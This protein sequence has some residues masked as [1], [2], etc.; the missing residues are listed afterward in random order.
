MQVFWDDGSFS[1]DFSL[2]GSESWSLML[3]VACK[4]WH[5]SGTRARSGAGGGNFIL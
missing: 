5:G 4:L 2:T 3:L 1:L